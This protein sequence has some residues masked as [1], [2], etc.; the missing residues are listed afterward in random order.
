MS[1]KH[2]LPL[3][4][5]PILIRILNW[6]YATQLPAAAAFPARVR[7]YPKGPKTKPAVNALWCFLSFSAPFSRIG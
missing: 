1:T 7:I 3:S 5:P 2:C 6:G 4:P